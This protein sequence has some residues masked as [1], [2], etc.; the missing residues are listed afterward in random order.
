MQD[1][2]YRATVDNS[3]SFLLGLEVTLFTALYLDII[4]IIYFYWCVSQNSKKEVIE[5]QENGRPK[6]KAKRQDIDY[7]SMGGEEV[8]EE[9]KKKSAEKEDE[10]INEWIKLSSDLH[11]EPRQAYVGNRL[12]T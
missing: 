7:S 8:T 2:L 10:E 6:R 11:W 4:L 5:Y 1:E 3:I 12:K 9:L